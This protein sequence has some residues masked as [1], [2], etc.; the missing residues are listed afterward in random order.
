MI[1]GLR[2][3]KNLFQNSKGCAVLWTRLV[4]WFKL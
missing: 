2:M 1:K 3:N 4:I